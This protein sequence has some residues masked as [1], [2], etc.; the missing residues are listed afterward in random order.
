MTK[1]NS[2]LKQWKKI[3]IESLTVIA[4][5][6]LAF[7]I[8]AYW[9]LRQDRDAE[10]EVI[11]A[12]YTEML[13][14]RKTLLESIKLNDDAVKH[15]ARLLKLNPEVLIQEK[16]DF[17]VID[18]IWAPYT[19]APEVGVLSVFLDKDTMVSD[20]ARLLQR[21]AINWQSTLI[22]S[23]EEAK[24]MFE[25]SA[26]VLKLITKYL[27]GIVPSEN[28]QHTLSLHLTV[29]TY[30]SIEKWMMTIM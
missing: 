3:F 24:A 11:G 1:W 27:T 17:K 21:I 6:L 19:Y 15:F 13:G 14:N 9:E 8:D 10:E 20:E 12:L 18:S 2:N 28:G 25:S 22:D 26:E 7:G 30:F 5:I 23:D 16:Y 4:S 29:S